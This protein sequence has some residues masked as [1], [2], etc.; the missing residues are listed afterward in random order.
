M[1]SIVEYVHSTKRFGSEKGH[2]GEMMLMYSDGTW[3]KIFEYRWS[4]PFNVRVIN[5]KLLVGKTRKE[6]V[7]RL[8]KLYYEGKL[9][10]IFKD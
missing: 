10:G 9:E 8:E 4:D 5:A 2:W 1:N 6:A 7:E 3:E